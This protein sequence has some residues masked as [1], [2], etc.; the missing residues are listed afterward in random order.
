M[1]MRASAGGG[2]K[3]VDFFVIAGAFGYIHFNS[4]F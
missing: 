4:E 3:A 2:E 1:H